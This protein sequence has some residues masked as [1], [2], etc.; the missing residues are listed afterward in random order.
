[1]SDGG[2]EQ[3]VGRIGRLSVPIGVNL[4]GEVIVHI[5]GGSEAFTAY[6]TGEEPLPVNTRVVV[7]EQ[8]SPRVVLVTGC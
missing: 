6:T 1:M 5:R 4:P 7:V 2:G 3:A 8:L